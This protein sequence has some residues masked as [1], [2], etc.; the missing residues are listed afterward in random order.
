MDEYEHATIGKYQHGDYSKI[1]RNICV[2]C[3]DLRFTSRVWKEFEDAMGKKLTF[4]T[5]FN[6]RPMDN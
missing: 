6:H 5:T 2:Y 1:A 3:V 4:S